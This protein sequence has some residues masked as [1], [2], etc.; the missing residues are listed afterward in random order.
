MTRVLVVLAALLACAGCAASVSVAAPARSPMLADLE[1]DK[2]IHELSPG[3]VARLESS[4]A[5]VLSEGP[6]MIDAILEEIR[7]ADN[8]QRRLMLIRMLHLALED[9]PSAADRLAHNRNIERSARRM[10]SDQDGD[11]RYAGLLLMGLPQ[12]SRVVPTAVEMLEDPDEDNR[13]FALSVLVQVAG[14]DFGFR[15]GGDAAERRA[16][17]DRWKSWWR[18]NRSRDV[19]YQPPANPILM[20]FRAE[21]NRITSNAGPYAVQVRDE[22]GNPIPDAIVAYSYSFSTADGIGRVI[23]GRETTDAHGRALTGGERVVTGF[24][25]L[26]AQLIVS[27]IGYQREA[28]RILPHFLTPNSFS[29]EVVL[30]RQ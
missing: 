13:R 22:E 28:L 19:Y 9:I 18:E 14:R 23:N 6:E 24:Q 25:Y 11:I 26:G 30:E 4:A 7:L 8:P 15:P 21:T 12:E 5:S 1:L 29:I 16:A 17:V 3:E 10:L 27:K 2:P 20:G